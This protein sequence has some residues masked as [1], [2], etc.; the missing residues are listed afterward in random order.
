MTPVSMVFGRE[1]RLHCDLKFGA[2]AD[3]EFSVACYSADL[4]EQI[5]DNHHIS[6]QHL[7]IARNRMKARYGQMSKLAGY[8]ED[9][10]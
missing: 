5:H 1:L 7:K 8:Q 3:K 2:P 10:R 6:R 9:D 4:V